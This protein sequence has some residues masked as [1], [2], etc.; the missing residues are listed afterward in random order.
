MKKLIVLLVMVTLFVSAAHAE[1]NR[2]TVAK[3]TVKAGSWLNVRK[4]PGGDLTFL[5]LYP[6]EDAVILEEQD[7]WAL[8]NTVK[9]MEEGRPAMG[10]SSMEYLLPYWEYV[11]K[12]PCA[13]TQGSK[14][15]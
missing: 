2:Y 10:W 7:G 1:M 6:W 14:E 11:Q 8:V 15:Q 3:V 9:R 13:A 12:E 5:V 4:T